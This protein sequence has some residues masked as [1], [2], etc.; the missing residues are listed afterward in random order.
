MNTIFPKTC[1]ITGHRDIPEEK[2]LFIQEALQNEINAAI[3]DGYRRFL[4]GF[5]LG[6]DILFARLVIEAK[7]AYPDIILEAALPYPTWMNHRKKEDKVL[8]ASCSAVGVHSPAYSQ[9]CFSV[10]NRYMAEESSRVIAV[11]DGRPKGGTINT[12]R[13]ARLLG[14]DVRMIPA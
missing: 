6:A 7:K 11:Y 2:V 13:H 12:L 14:K 10:R 3:R 5:A 9:A 1:C 4:S 8:L